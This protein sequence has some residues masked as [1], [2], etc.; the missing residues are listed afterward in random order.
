M[1]EDIDAKDKEIF[2]LEYKLA[3][4]RRARNQGLDKGKKELSVLKET[5]T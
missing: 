4:L 3:D 2:D 5:A 1:Q